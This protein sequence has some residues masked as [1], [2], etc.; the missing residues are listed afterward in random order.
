VTIQTFGPVWTPVP[1][2]FNASAPSLGLISTLNASAHKFAY[3][4]RVPKTGTLD[5]F[6]YRMGTV[7]NNPDNGLRLSFQDVDLTTGDPDGVQDQFRDM[8]G[9]FVTG[10]WQAPGL[11]TSDGTDSGTKRSVTAGDLLACVI[12]FVS[13]VASDS[14]TMVGLA[15][16]ATAP[17]A[18]SG[19]FPYVDTF[20]AAWSKNYSPSTAVLKYSDGSYASF[21]LLWYP[22]LNVNTTTYN[23][24][25]TPDERGMVFQVPIKCQV[26]GF[27]VHADLDG[28]ADIVLYDAASSVV[29]TVST[30]TDVRSQTS[31]AN[32]YYACAPTTLTANVLYRLVVKP[33]S[34]TNISTY[35]FDVN[36]DNLMQVVE[37]GTN[38]YYTQ[39][40]DAGAWTD[41][42][43]KRPWMGLQISGIDD[44]A[45]GYVPVA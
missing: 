34:V 17:Q 33:T 35:D 27:W 9:T 26:S 15:T 8:T 25:S 40:T 1:A 31:G 11:M 45:G 16:S 18:L 42:T 6:E 19:N 28:D 23:S 39:R 36:A 30:D 41:T 7:N 43:T 32:G 38:A 5:K 13:F 44:G 3:V 29:L 2:V 37:L 24:G 14:I 22:Y 20:A 21:G 12:E 4:G 10:A